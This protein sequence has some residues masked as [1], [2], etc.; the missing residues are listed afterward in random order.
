VRY[1]GNRSTGKMGFAVARAAARRGARVTLVA[2]PTALDTP[3]GCDRINVESALEMRE[4]VM[5]RADQQAA[6]VM[7]AAVADYRP[8][9][10]GEQKLKKETLG[11]SP[12]VALTANPDILAEQGARGRRMPVLIGFAA[13]TE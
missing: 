7:T 12:S 3:P 11:E 4:A 9:A 10:V 5:T 13:E 1:V 8:A 6:I 2:G